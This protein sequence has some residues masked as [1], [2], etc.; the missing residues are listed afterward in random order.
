[1]SEYQ[2]YAVLM[3]I[4]EPIII[5]KG[6]RWMVLKKPAGMI[7]HPANGDF[8]DLLTWSKAELDKDKDLAKFCD[9]DPNYELHVIHRLDREV[10]G[11]VL[12]ALDKK[13]ANHLHKQFE[14][15]EIIKAYQA[16]VNVSDKIEEEGEWSWKITKKAEGRSNPAGFKK[17]RVPCS[18]SY[19]ILEKQ[20]EHIRLELVPNTGRKHQLRRHCAMAGVPILGESRYHNY[21]A[22]HPLYLFSTKLGFTDPNNGEKHLFEIKA[23]F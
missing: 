23:D 14:N 12:V 20:D 8:N 1:M 10:G 3:E 22:E 18:T 19:K 16:L 21:E 9:Y 11:L 15:R 17:F 5:G 4:K 7:V 2:L 13:R 6:E